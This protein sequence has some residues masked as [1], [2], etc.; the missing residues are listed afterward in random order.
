MFKTLKS[1]FNYIIANEPFRRLSMESKAS[2]AYQTN[3]TAFSNTMFP[4]VGIETVRYMSTD[5]NM[6]LLR[7][8][9]SQDTFDFRFVSDS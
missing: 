8:G 1:N 6:S 4:I 7:V 3:K 9:I 2:R 5:C